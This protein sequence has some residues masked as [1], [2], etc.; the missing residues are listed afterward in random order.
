[1]VIATMAGPEPSILTAASAPTA[2]IAEL[3][4]HR[5]ATI[6]IIRITRIIRI[7]RITRI[8][9][10]IRIYIYHIL[11]IRRPH[12]LRR[13]STARTPTAQARATTM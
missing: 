9:R 1:M 4:H 6:R 7:I 10:I 5:T 13:T 8:T 2:G 12:H 3:G 11:T